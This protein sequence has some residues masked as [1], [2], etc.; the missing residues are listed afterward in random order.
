LVFGEITGRIGILLFGFGCNFVQFKKNWPP[1]DSF[2]GLRR[3][4]EHTKASR[5]LV[6]VQLSNTAAN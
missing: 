1:L 6:R 3:G 2:F 5:T 4:Y